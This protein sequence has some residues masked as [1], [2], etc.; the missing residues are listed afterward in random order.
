MRLL[1]L[2][3]AGRLLLTDFGGKTTPPYAILSHRWGDSEVLFGDIMNKRYKEKEGYRKIEFCAK[4]TAEDQLQYFWIDTCCI[5]KWNV[6]E[7]SKSINSMFLWYKGVQKCYVFMP[8]VTVFTATDQQKDWEASFRASEWFRRGWTLQELIAPESVEFFSQE[9][10]LLGDKQSLEQLVHEI[11]YIPIAALQGCPLDKFTIP[12]KMEWT[13]NRQ[14]TEEEDIVY[15]LLGILDVYMP[16]SYGEGRV[17]ARMR[18]EAEIDGSV[19]F[20]IPFSRN[21]DFVGRES[22]LVELE[23]KLF[24][25]K[26]TR[27]VTIAGPGG[28]G[29]SQLALELAYRVRRQNKSC[30]IFW[31]DAS[32]VNGVHQSYASIAQKLKVPG[33]KEEKADVKQLIKLHLSRKDAGQSLL[34]FDNADGASFVSDRPFTMRDVNLT[35]YLPESDLC[36]VLFTTTDSN[37]AETLLCKEVVELHGVEQNTAQRMLEQYLDA[38][39]SKE[40]RLEAELLLQELSHLPLAIVQAAAYINTRRIKLQDYRIQLAKQQQKTL[41]SNSQSPK[42]RLQPHRNESPVAAT[43]FLSVE[44][45]C[46]DSPLAAEYLFFAACVDRK[47]VLFE[48][49]EA[50]SRREREDAIRVLNNYKLVTRRPAESALD[51]HRLVHGALRRWLRKQEMLGEWTETTIIRLFRVF[52]DA[53]LGNRS[54]WRRMLSHAK[55]TLSHSPSKQQGENRIKLARVYAVAL[56]IDGWYMESEELL[57]QVVKRDKAVLGEEHPNTL[58]NMGNLASTYSKQGQWKKAEALRVQVMETRK[59]VLGEEHPDTLTSIANLALT[60]KNRGKMN[61]AVFLMRG[62]YTSRVNVLGSQHP[63]TTSAH[64]ALTTWQLQDMKLDKQIDL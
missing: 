31:I 38:P 11:T 49:L 25:S 36:S 27:F 30:S 20:M 21:D 23:A 1:H 34:I 32:S 26:Q 58:T 44:H 41:E 64:I 60:F 17:K 24:E 61:E 51:L 40:D 57:L 10:R 12:E 14:T 37:A 46:G 52:P 50:P 47:D 6:D 56:M 3:Q 4:Q 48:F 9:G 33:W 54:K 7:L 59:K 43:L 13:D 5:D 39:M 55:Y 29:K 53:S 42:V 19:P 62:C 22:Q 16:T 28:T 15:C 63:D 8:D 18:L 35:D 2:D 45:L